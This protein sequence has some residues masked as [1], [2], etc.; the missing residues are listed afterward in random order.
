MLRLAYSLAATTG[1][2]I[3]YIDGKGDRQTQERFAAL[4]AHA[5]RSV[6]L[7]PEQ[8]YDGWRGSAEEIANRL[9][10]LIDFAQEGGGTYYRDL[11]VTAVRL[12]CCTPLG[13]PTSSEELLRRLSQRTLAHLHAGQPGAGQVASL[14]S[15]EIDAIR[16]RYAAFF[17]TVG[18]SLDG[19]L[20]FEE[21]DSAYFL[22]DG[23]RLKYE[24]GYLA[25]FLVEEFTQWAVERKPR[26]QRV[27]LIVD[28]FSAIAQASQGLVN[29]V[30]RA[31][32][33]GVA[34]VLC[35]QVAEG[36]GGIEATARILGSAQTILLHATALPSQLVDVAGTRRVYE[37]AHQLD[38]DA[39]TGLGSAR[40]QHE[41][42]VDPDEVRRLQ[43]GQC[44]AISPGRAMKLH[45]VPAPTLASLHEQ[46]HPDRVS[47]RSGVW[48]GD[49]AG[50]LLLVSCF[51]PVGL[52]R[53]DHAARRPAPAH[54][55]SPTSLNRDAPLRGALRVGAPP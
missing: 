22:L 32:G 38:N 39:T 52:D 16:A 15:E 53:L 17:I 12:A 30:E 41:Y 54:G 31:R 21:V 14:R 6:A 43:V 35:P 26:E 8:R 28:E 49:Q 25:R 13:P 4:M 44:F 24:A 37:Y 36:M 20:S 33:F 40:L 1:W 10:Q 27:L 3:V 42:R 19:E 23:L 29:V 47:S 34:A 48:C 46:P 18:E 51:V 45:I 55:R 11:A 2:T 50:V 7:F 5:G 9:L